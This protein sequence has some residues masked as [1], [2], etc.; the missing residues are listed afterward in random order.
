MKV[1]VGLI[2]AAVLVGVG[3]YALDLNGQADERHA[4]AVAA[5]HAEFQGRLETE[6]QVRAICQERQDF[7]VL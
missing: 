3:L 5:H 2:L 7:Q 6:K 4:Q 1:M